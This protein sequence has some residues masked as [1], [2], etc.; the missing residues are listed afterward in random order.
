MPMNMAQASADIKRAE[1]ARI[2]RYANVD[3]F[4]LGVKSVGFW[5]LRIIMYILTVPVII[6]VVASASGVV[7]FIFGYLLGWAW[8]IP[9][10]AIHDRHN[11]LRGRLQH[12]TWLMT[13]MSV[14]GRG[15]P[16][17]PVNIC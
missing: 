6:L 2:D 12:D 8:V 15:D 4:W 3:P 14:G 11:A 7:T 5:I 10:Q 9:Y 17:R 13:L 16:P 1:Q